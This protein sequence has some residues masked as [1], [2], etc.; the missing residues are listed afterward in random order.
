[1]SQPVLKTSSVE[2]VNEDLPENPL[3]MA[4]DASEAA[5]AAF[6]HDDNDIVP[7]LVD[8]STE[9]TWAAANSVSNTEIE[10]TSA[11]ANAADVLTDGNLDD[12]PDS[13]DEG[14]TGPTRAQVDPDQDGTEVHVA[15]PEAG[16]RKARTLD[17]QRRALKWK[18]GMYRLPLHQ[19]KLNYPTSSRNKI[20]YTDDEDRF[21]LVMLDRFGIDSEDIYQRIRDEIRE[22]PLLRFNWFM[23]NRNVGEIARRCATLLDIVSR[24]FEAYE[25]QKSNSVSKV[26][27]NS[28]QCHKLTSC[29]G[30]K[31]SAKLTARVV[32]KDAA[33]RTR[34]HD[35]KR[36]LAVSDPVS[37]AI[38]GLPIALSILLLVIIATMENTWS[39]AITVLLL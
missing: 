20:V 2:Q 28:R 3:E 24:E 34:N 36:G 11:D 7:D 4:Q 22:S 23:L 25:G 21:L 1:M 13:V 31:S 17:L 39:T 32:A 5:P 26:N 35:T 16:G 9:P 37:E 33:D 14:V 6:P 12:L 10:P 8:D 15:K 18:M 27:G 19:L 29:E 30:C 38:G